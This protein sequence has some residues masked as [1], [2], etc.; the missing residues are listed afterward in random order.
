MCG[1]DGNH[2]K[3]DGVNKQVV[4]PTLFTSQ[5]SGD[6]PQVTFTRHTNKGRKS[7]PGGDTRGRVIGRQLLSWAFLCLSHLLAKGPSLNC[8]SILSWRIV[9]LLEGYCLHTYN[10]QNYSDIDVRIYYHHYTEINKIKFRL[11]AVRLSLFRK[12]TKE[13]R[14]IRKWGWMWFANEYLIIFFIVNT[15]MVQML[16]IRRGQTNIWGQEV[17]YLNNSF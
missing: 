3:Q 5:A 9:Y 15:N 8:P 11:V 17:K 1:Q 4:L 6:L 16:H 13:W 14:F 2:K 10:W 7:S 12:L